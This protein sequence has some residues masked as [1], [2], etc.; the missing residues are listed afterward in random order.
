MICNKCK[1]DWDV[2]GTSRTRKDGYQDYQCKCGSK[3]MPVVSRVLVIPDLHYPFAKEGHL[4]FLSDLYNKYEC[5]SVVCTGDILDNHISSY[6][7]NSP[8]AMGASAELDKA[9]ESVIALASIFPDMKVC[10][11]NHDALPD[12]KA[13]TGG[14]APRWIRTVKE[15]L[16]AAGAPVEGWEFADHWD[17]DGV[18]YT[19]GTGRQAKARM[20]QDGI[21]ITQGHYHSRSS[22]EWLSN[23]QRTTF[24]MQLG[25]LIDSKEYAFHYGKAFADPFLNAG[26]VIDGKVP[27]IEYM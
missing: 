22:I 21:S 1:S 10:I 15:V 19:H 7:E 2:T 27:I 9:V 12:R 18:R 17:F 6:H 4:E 14:I 26:I 20:V 13:F 11:G 23:A 16:I 24:A 5:N 25:C 3:A 8:S